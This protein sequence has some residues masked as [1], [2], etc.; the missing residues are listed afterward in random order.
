M[1]D[2]GGTASGGNT[3]PGPS[4]AAP[5]TVVQSPDAAARAA[6]E[7]AAGE[8]TGPA[9]AGYEVLGELGRGAMGVVFKARHIKLNR[10]VALKMT[11]GGR[12]DD[13]DLIRFLAEAEAVAAVKHGNV[14]QVYDYGESGGRPYMAL[15]FCPGGPL[16][17]RL[18]AGEPLTARA[19]AETV[20]RIAAGVAAAHE[21]GIVHRDLKPGNVLL[22]ADGEP[23]VADF[24]LA[25]RAAS[26]LTATQAVMGTP[27]YMSPEQAGGKT[28]FVGPQA[29]VWSLGVILYECLTGARPFPGAT[30]EEVLAQVL[31]AEPP[32]I[33]TAKPDVPRDVDLICR[34]CLEKNPADRYPTARELAD[35]LERFGRGEPISVRPLGTARRTA[36]WARRNPAVAGLLG[37]VAVITL[38]LIG[39]LYGMYNAEKDKKEIAERKVE[40]DAALLNAER[41]AAEE[42]LRVVAEQEVTR[43]A[44]AM[45]N[46]LVALL[47]GMFRSSD[48]LVTFFGDDVPGFAAPTGGEGRATALGPFLR[49]AADRFRETLTGPSVALVRAK[50]L[51]SIGKGMKNL[52]MFAEGKKALAEALELRLS[53]LSP[54]HPDVLRSRLDLAQLDAE[55]GALLEAVD[56]FRAIH[57]LQQSAGAEEKTLL[58][59]RM[60]E[61]GTLAML[62]APEAE[63]VLLDVIAARRRIGASNKDIILAELALVGCY[64]DY[65][66]ITKLSLLCAELQ[67]D[68][69]AISDPRIRKMF[70]LLFECQVKVA[71]GQSGDNPL[72]A[73]S[74]G[75]RGIADGIKK[76]LARLV[77]EKLL[78]ED[79]I[80]LSV[81]R[82]E[83][84][85]LL[86]EAR[87]GEEGD[88]LYA[89]VLADV[90][91]TVGLAHPKVILLL[92]AFSERL[93][94][95]N[96]AGEARDLFAQ[97]EAANRE[98]F[99]P[100]N[101]W[102]ASVLL[103]RAAFESRQGRADAALGYAKDASALLARGKFL[104]N[105]NSIHQLIATA[106]AVGGGPSRPH[107]V[108]ARELFA[109]LHPL[110]E[111]VY[112]PDS[113]EMVLLL[114]REGRHLYDT[115]AY[116]AALVVLGRASERFAAHPNIE[117]MAR[118]IVHFRCG[119]LA[120]DRG[121]FAEAEGHF[122]ATRTAGK[123]V[124]N[125]AV[126]DRVVFPSRLASALA[127]QGRFKEALPLIEE[128]RRCAAELKGLPEW[129]RAFRD[130]QV[131]T[132]QLA[133]GDRD[134]Y[135]RTIEK[136]I[137]QYEKSKDG[138]TLARL[139]WAGGL[140]ARRDG[141]D[142]VAFETQFAAAFK[143]NTPHPWEYR[144]LA[145]VRLR[146]GLFD[147]VEEALAKA[148]VPV[149]PVDHVIRGLVAVARKDGPAARAHLAKAEALIEAEKPGEK[150]PFAYAGRA[151]NQHVEAA[152]LLAELRA[153][154][155]PPVAPPPHAAKR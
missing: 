42:K 104:S 152:I 138:N 126:V 105:P 21:E 44:E 11:L 72:A 22:A 66:R 12:A 40:A 106:S 73:L 18:R 151:W 146:A 144:G 107:W 96:R 60:F 41:T 125:L 113:E 3:D 155:A 110:V 77:E 69:Q 98:R 141:W 153:A 4:D 115:G 47:D 30:A 34:K 61:G 135:R 20:G 87:M 150:N 23:K 85:R 134:A 112:G 16:S 109:A 15:E 124:P 63:T 83:L 32:P 62:S 17:E 133:A 6:V 139:A 103:L 120:L 92:T 33:R 26:D 108:V 127:A 7:S 39:A 95:T 48:P 90:K 55:S 57:A 8:R 19:A 27:S 93:A 137:E 131:A 65:Q 100:E 94:A 99:G 46:E 54:T 37:A 118:V 130:M 29:D 43:S 59:T 76:N 53:K 75:P 52:G 97:V 79:H 2:G 145:L 36:R 111:K 13:K 80:V 136:M 81:F 10:V 68:I 101:S 123:Q 129:E 78:P 88:A 35:D 140:S 50:L 148:G 154:L 82:F 147:G 14:V 91:K 31:S 38:G 70:N 102:L 143:P 132:C 119:L 25:K 142:A 122:R 74:G 24:G 121:R 45:A 56:Q 9:V 89:R 128:A 116:A 149:L 49:N 114:V 71:L 86:V 67:E 51:S 1:P 58:T 117:P 28:K 84:A 5:G 64:V